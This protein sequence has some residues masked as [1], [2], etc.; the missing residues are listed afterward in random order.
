MISP[1]PRDTSQFIEQQPYQKR[2][3]SYE[4]FEKLAEEIQ[5]RQTSPLFLGECG[6][7]RM[8]WVLKSLMFAKDDVHGR[9]S[10]ASAGRARA[11]DDP[12]STGSSN[13]GQSSA[14]EFLKYVNR[15]VPN[16]GVAS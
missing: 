2:H 4:Q 10:G 11:T 14:H 13:A 5:Q 9:T 6:L 8:D 12:Q 16:F 3:L 7:Q 1:D 15:C